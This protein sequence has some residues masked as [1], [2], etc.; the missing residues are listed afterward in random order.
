MKK[1]AVVASFLWL[2]VAVSPNAAVAGEV[3]KGPRMRMDQTTHDLG[4]VREGTLVEHAF[5]VMNE[6]DE[7]LKILDVKPG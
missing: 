6:G 5:K 3:P 7:P 2:V 1:L 4:S